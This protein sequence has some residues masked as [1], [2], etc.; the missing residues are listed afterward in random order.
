MSWA[1]CPASSILLHL[2]GGHTAPK[3]LLYIY[4]TINPSVID[5]TSYETFNGF[6]S[7]VSIKEFSNQ[8]L[9][10]GRRQC[11][12]VRTS[13]QMRDHVKA[14]N[15]SESRLI[16]VDQGLNGYQVEGVRR[17]ESPQILQAFIGL[18]TV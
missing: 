4:N 18:D 10:F 13:I 15:E 7:W 11:H 2:D 5:R 16:E 12:K 1:Q 17:H 9:E 14:F 3:R 8:M 6:D